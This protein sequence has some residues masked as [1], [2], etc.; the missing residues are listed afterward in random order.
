MIAYELSKD[1]YLPVPPAFLAVG[2][3]NAPPGVLV[4][5]FYGYIGEPGRKFVHAIERLQARHFL[6]D[7]RRGSIKD[8]IDL[9]RI[10]K[11]PSW[12]SWWARTLGFDAVIGNTDRHSEN[13]GFLLEP[14]P[15]GPRYELAPA[16]D[17]G[18]SLG[19]IIREEDLN[20][21]LQPAA[22]ARLVTNG[23]H[24]AGWIAGDAASAQHAHLC[25]V[26][27]DH[28]PDVARIMDD[29][30][31]LSDNSIERVVEWCCNFSFPV[32][33]SEARAHL[34]SALVRSRRDNLAAALGA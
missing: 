23:K 4:E 30:V 19:C 17:N 33:F 1:L 34:V 10:H 32:P 18:T 21:F 3:G 5:F 14:T 16:F 31:G 20:K 8:N 27:K 2:P 29:T 7:H 22:L 25:R 11:T 9:C 13:W 15:T 24:H 12:R 28:V 6:F 26:Y